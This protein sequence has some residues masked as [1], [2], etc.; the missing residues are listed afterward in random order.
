[1]VQLNEY[2]LLS[3]ATEEE[4]REKCSGIS[5][6]KGGILNNAVNLVPGTFEA[7]LE[8]GVIPAQWKKYYFLNSL[9]NALNYHRIKNAFV[10]QVF[11]YIW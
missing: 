5:D 9:K 4:L 11:P 7:F 10:C 8:D 6:N 3:P 1:M 2:A